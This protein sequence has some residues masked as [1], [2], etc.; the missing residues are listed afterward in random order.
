MEGHYVFF[1]LLMLLTMSNP[2]ITVLFPWRKLKFTQQ[3]PNRLAFTVNMLSL[4]WEEAPQIL[5]QTLAASQDNAD[6]HSILY[7]IFE[8]CLT[9]FG[10]SFG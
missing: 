7:I 9:I 1:A 4:L 6:F 8:P 5:V 10:E 3:Y 2:Q